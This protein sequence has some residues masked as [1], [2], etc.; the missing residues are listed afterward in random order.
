MKKRE[1]LLG[2]SLALGV[3]QAQAAPFG[4]FDPRSM[5]MGG[6][7]VATGTSANASYFN[8]ALLAAAQ[9]DEDFSLEFPIV[10]ARVADP[11]DLVSNLDD[12]QE[13]DYIDSFSTA[14]DEWNAALDAS[15]PTVEKAQAVVDT[16]QD[17]L[18]GFVTLSDRTLEAQINAGLVIG[19]PSK[20][21]GAAVYVNANA[22]GG[23]M[24][25]VAQSDRDNVQAILD[26]LQNAIDVYNGSGDP[27]DLG[28]AGQQVDP[29]SNLESKLFGRGAV[30]GEVGISLARDF[31][32]IAVGITPKFQQIETFDYALDIES[33]DVTV[34]EGRKTDNGF[35]ID[36]GVAKDFGNGWKLGLTAKN[37]ISKTYETARGN[38]FEIKPQ[39]RAGAGYRWGWVSVAA[40]LDLTKNDPAGLDRETKYAAV[41]AELDVWKTVQLR[42][43]YRHN[44]E[45]SDTSVA[46]LGLGMSPFGVHLDIAVAGNDEEVAAAIQT[47][48]R[49]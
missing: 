47:G 24:L 6:A 39:Y 35:N 4:Y 20:R 11:D 40:D 31:S 17:L 44:M 38:D 16:G 3:A 27:N 7:G 26:D 23:A 9:K 37:L 48:F 15:N 46:S 45:D 49:F 25:S 30:V 34:D 10:G 13:A 43:G 2:I 19:I 18:D 21:F 5:G 1:L 36:A 41:G 14:I 28:S 8:P 42:V 29:T 22:M 32:G 33:A 12:F